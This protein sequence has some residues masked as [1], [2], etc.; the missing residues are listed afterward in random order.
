MLPI[1]PASIYLAKLPKQKITAGLA[2]AENARKIY[3]Q[4]GQS[5]GTSADIWQDIFA[6]ALAVVDPALGLEKWKPKGSVELGETRTRTL[7]WLTA[8][9]EMGSPK[10]DITADTMM[11]GVFERA[12]DGQR[13]YVAYNAQ[14][15]KRK[16]SFSDGH[17]MLVEPGQ[18]GRATRARP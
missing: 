17:E 11:Y 15:D 2:Y 6:S 18:L 14:K 8:L 1:T 9:N 7:H 10:L 16:I 12:T 3:D 5:D 13:T 4:K